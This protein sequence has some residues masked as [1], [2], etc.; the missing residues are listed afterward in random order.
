[1]SYELFNPLTKEEELKKHVDK[2]EQSESN[3]HAQNSKQIVHESKKDTKK[4]KNSRL[5][6]RPHSNYLK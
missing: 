1:M 2:I 3:Y 5:I 4:M 6:A